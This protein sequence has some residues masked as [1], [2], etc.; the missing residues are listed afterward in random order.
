MQIK[1]ST[2]PQV[3]EYLKEK[4]GI[5]IPIG[6]TEQH[7]PSGPIGTDA[8][9]AEVIANAIGDKYDVM[10]APTIQVGMSIHHTCFPGSM[11][12]SPNV[13]S[14]I[15]D[16]YCLGLAK[17]G[18]R[19]FYFVNGHGGNIHP[20]HAAFGNMSVKLSFTTLPYANDLRFGIKSWWENEAVANLCQELYGD[21]DGGHATA[22]E[23]SIAMAASPQHDYS[24]DVLPP[25]GETH[26]GGNYDSNAFCKSF[27]D[28]RINSDPTLSNPE[29]GQRLIALA[30]DELYKDYVNFC[31]TSDWC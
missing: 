1:Y 26:C 22:S 28:G 30:A 3:G 12:H 19:E 11:T 13:L 15:V 14:Q 7:G 24:C 29:D 21:K 2:W 10:V 6:A 31:T 16:E 25:V 18:F 9:C 20:T 4:T 5:I 17:H 23:I 8:I 27:P